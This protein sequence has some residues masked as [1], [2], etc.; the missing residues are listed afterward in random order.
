MNNKKL[1][2]IISLCLIALMMLS[3]TACNNKDGGSTPD[4]STASTSSSALTESTA[5]TEASSTAA[6]SSTAPSSTAET[7]TAAEAAQNA[8]SGSQSG[9]QGGQTS[10]VA[11][12]V[13]PNGDEIIGAGSKSQPYLETPDSNMTVKTV[14]V[15]AGKALYYDIYRVG[16]KYLTINDSDAY[17]IYDGTRYES[18][19]G[20]VSF[21]VG[22]ALASDAVS[23]QIGNSGSTAKS[24][25][26]CFYDLYG[27]YDNPE[28]IS[29]MDGKEITISLSAGND[30]GYNYK[31]IAEKSG[32][33][34]FY[35]KNELNTFLFSATR[36]KSSDGMLIPVQSTF[37]EEV[38]SDSNGNYIEVEVLKGETVMIAVSA[39]PKGAYYPAVTVKWYG[40]YAN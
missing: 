29:K 32:T 2:S 33:I 1:F 23:F 10:T 22:S 16:G 6:S 35:V 15:P 8:Q 7:S 21:V 4:E 13:N 34:R 17:V 5:S 40:I 31:Y 26:I 25:E 36:N 20:K 30:T 12:A 18:S 37:M 38:K 9:S 3:F 11:V 39:Y 19:G 14:K 28:I 27:A 24:F